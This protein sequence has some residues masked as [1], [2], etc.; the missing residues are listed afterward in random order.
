MGSNPKVNRR[1]PARVGVR[2]NE[3]LGL[4]ADAQGLT[5]TQADPQGWAPSLSLR[6]G[7]K[8]ER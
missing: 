4:V 6:S 8:G 3:E 2:L 7:R 5:N 1:P